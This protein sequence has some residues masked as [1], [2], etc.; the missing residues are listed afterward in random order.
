MDIDNDGDGYD[1]STK[2]LVQ[3]GLFDKM[4]NGFFDGDEFER[5]DWKKHSKLRIYSDSKSKWFNGE[6]IDIFTDNQ[7]EWLKIRYDGFSIKEV[8]RFS[9]WIKT[10]D[11]LNDTAPYLNAPMTIY[12]GSQRADEVKSNDWDEFGDTGNIAYIIHFTT[13]SKLVCSV[14]NQWERIEN[15]NSTW[16]TDNVL[17]IIIKYIH[18]AHKG[19]IN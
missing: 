10:M 3:T 1:P 18:E 12:I 2:G 13:L 9:K 4:E 5:L 14:L 16:K 7:G 15:Y 8:Q 6:I 19:M 11:D 17:N